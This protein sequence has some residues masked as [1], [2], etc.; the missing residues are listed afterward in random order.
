M[1]FEIMG[2]PYSLEDGDEIKSRA[3]KLRQRLENAFMNHC[4]D[5]L[6]VDFP[7]RGFLL[8]WQLTLDQ[9]LRYFEVE[10]Q[11][12]ALKNKADSTLRRQKLDELLKFLGANPVKKVDRAF[13]EAYGSGMMEY[14]NL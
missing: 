12:A 14:L 10:P 1:Y 5:I 13:K 11:I 9:K 4:Y 6:G 7:E 2:H 8:F 3:M